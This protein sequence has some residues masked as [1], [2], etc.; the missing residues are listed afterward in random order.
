MLFRSLRFTLAR[1]GPARLE[2]FDAGGRRVRTL[3][4][5]DLAAG[6]HEATWDGRDDRGRAVAAGAY[7]AR[8]AGAGGGC[9]LGLT[10]LR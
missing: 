8:L 7:V 10:L 6:D 4:A 5:G 1:G 3:L 2:L 9:S